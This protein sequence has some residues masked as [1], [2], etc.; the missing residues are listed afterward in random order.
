MA[1]R[2][3]A[4]DTLRGLTVPALVVVGDED[5][6]A[7]QDEARAMADALPDAELLVVPGAGHLCTVERPDAFNDAVAEFA[8]ALT[9]AAR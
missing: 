4:F 5:A 1:A 8:A 7:V 9:R 3:P 2:G 6:L